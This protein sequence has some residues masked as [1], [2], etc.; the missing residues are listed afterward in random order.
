[1]ADS[2]CLS[3]YLFTPPT[4]MPLYSIEDSQKLGVKFEGHC[5][6]RNQLVNK[7]STCPQYQRKRY[8]TRHERVLCR[9]L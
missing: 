4:M 6:I 2:L 9:I 8:M 5:E 7:V 1:M 3:C